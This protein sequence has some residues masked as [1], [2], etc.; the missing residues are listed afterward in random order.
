MSVSGPA[1]E[2][3]AAETVR[4][5]LGARGYDIVVGAGVLA[6]AAELLEPVLEGG[7][8][9]VVTD[10]TVAALHLPTLSAALDGAGIGHDVVVLPPGETTKSFRE[11]EKLIEQLLATE[12]GRDGTIVALGGGV[13]GDM[14][15][16]A[17][18]VLRRGIGYVQAPTTLLAQVDSSVGGKTG[19]NTRHG[20]NLAGAFHQPLLVLADTGT[21]DTLPERQFLSGYAEMAKYGLTADADFFSWLEAHGGELRGDEDA[22]RRAVI[23]SCTIK[24]AIV[25]EDERETGRRALL[26][27]GHTFG[28]ALET[29]AGYS[30]DL[31]HG[32]AVA[33]GMV[34]AFELSARLGLCP[35]EDAERVRTHL[36]QIG[37]PTA[38]GDRQPAGVVWRPDALVERMRQDKKVRQGKVKFVLARGIGDAFVAEDVDLAQVRA[39]L[40]DTLAR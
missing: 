10:R 4:V 30:D 29:E 24:A 2:A 18:S 1:A 7:R 32:E 20:K 25:V 26:N 11:F 3:T 16:F 31:L 19:I 12:I 21:I 23:E 37:L 34:L 40:E 5:D 8:V 33:I 13:V 15:G 6:R 28:H 22:R 27:L 36:R 38:P 35:A 14:A 17:A 9:A 39:L